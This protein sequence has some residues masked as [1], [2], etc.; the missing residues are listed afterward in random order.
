MKWTSIED[1]KLFWAYK[2][3]PRRWSD[4]S[5]LMEGR[6][7]SQCAQRFRRKFFLQKKMRKWTEDEDRKL[8]D[9][10]N[11]YGYNW[12]KLSSLGGFDR[13]GKQL[14]ERYLN[15]LD[16]SIKKEKWTDE[17]DN[18]I[19]EKFGEHGSKWSKISSFLPGRPEN[20]IK[21]RY[22]SYIRLKK[23]KKKKKDDN[24]CFESDLLI[25][26]Y[27]FEENLLKLRKN[28]ESSV[29]TLKPSFS[30]NSVKENLLEPYYCSLLPEDLLESNLLT[31]EKTL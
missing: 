19:I 11:K 2:K 15:V 18:I 4:I 25:E 16:P 7:A 14:R 6:N 22:Y 13:N 5:N 8:I 10:I 28:D 12:Q 1:E 29:L 27:R 23:G 31:T 30:S 3:F 17:E 21:N 20:A 26:N 9:L 24:S